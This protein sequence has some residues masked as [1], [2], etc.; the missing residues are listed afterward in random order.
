MSL[1]D[2]TRIVTIPDSCGGT[3]TAAT[4]DGLTPSRLEAYSNTE[5]ALARVIAEAAEARAVGVVPRSLDTL[6]MSRI[7]E[8]GK[9]QLMEK[10]VGTQSIVLPFTY[11]N[12]QTNTASDYFSIVSGEANAN[13]G[14]GSMPASAWDIVVSTGP[15]AWKSDLVALERYFLPGEYVFVENMKEGAAGT[16]TAYMTAFK[17]I[18]SVNV[19]TSTA[20]ITIAPNLTATYWGTLTEAQQAVYQPT[21]GVVQVGVNSVDDRESWCYNQVAEKNGSLLVDWHQTSRYTQC[22]NDE[23]LR[24]LNEIMKGN[25]NEY[26]KKFQYM[27]LAEQNRKQRMKFDA[28][29]RNSIF[30]GQAISEKQTAETYDELD[31]VVDPDDGTV[32]GYK[33]NALG[34]RTLLAA[35]SQVIDAA[36]G[37]LDLDLLFTLLY[38]IKRNREANGEVVTVIDLMTDKDTAHLLHIV[39]TKHLQ[40]TFGYN[41][42]QFYQPGKVI[43][44]SGVTNFTYNKYDIPEIGF[45]I[46]IFVDSY[47]TDRVTNFG[48]GSGGSNGSVNFKSRGR[49]IWAIDWSDFNVGIVATNSAKREYRGKV[50]ADANSL[51]S[52]VIT[53]NTKHYDLRST[54]WTTQLGDAKRHVLI[55]NFSLDTCP[56]VTLSR[57]APGYTA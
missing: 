48:D 39:L 30:Y 19:N 51:F 49:A 54:T 42:T 35:E 21:F 17:V 27:P 13:A 1:L 40:D 55:E 22:Y 33:A 32:Y 47:F 12:R 6:L 16:N 56:S 14:V 29:W 23:Y 5:H 57:C 20:K 36:G 9:G 53:P 41:V 52:C 15:S 31:Q 46:A 4:I 44:A 7:K 11:R 50:Y 25:V 18:A 45:Q 34:L 26:L 3:L 24:I 28:K 2:R 43:D 10:K 38:S 8:V 37:P